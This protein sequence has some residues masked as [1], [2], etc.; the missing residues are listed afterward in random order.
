MRG[1]EISETISR[2]GS[3]L[4]TFLPLKFQCKDT[5]LPEVQPWGSL[6]SDLTSSRNEASDCHQLSR[7]GRIYL[8]IIYD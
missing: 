2:L 8:H 1:D 5:Q 6:D 3:Q 7:I 4:S